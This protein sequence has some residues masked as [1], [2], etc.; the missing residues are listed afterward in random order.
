MSINL[1]NSIDLANSITHHHSLNNIVL[2]VC[3]TRV[4]CDEVS[5]FVTDPQDISFLINHAH[6]DESEE[7]LLIIGFETICGHVVFF[8]CSEDDDEQ[9]YRYSATISGYTYDVRTPS[10]VN[11]L[12]YVWKRNKSQTL[13]D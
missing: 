4:T 12:Q 11:Q 7:L 6:P 5:T 13:V 1:A 3:G 2:D 10:F 8:A 9:I